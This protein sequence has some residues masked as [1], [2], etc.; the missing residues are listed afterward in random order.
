[1]LEGLTHDQIIKEKR[2]LHFAPEANISNILKMYTESYTTADINDDHDIKLDISNMNIINDDEFDVVIACD[3][4]E[5]VKN[6]ISAMKEIFRI[7]NTNGYAI[8][9]VPQK[10]N[11]KKTYEDPSIISPEGRTHAYGQADHLRMYGDDFKQKLQDVGFSVTV[12][13]EN[14]FKKEESNKFVLF[15]PV[16]SKHPL[17]TNYRKVFFARK[18]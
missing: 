8:L 15:P 2:V 7:L 9:L 12:V 17:A 14:N 16:L 18:I 6:D 3:V 13:D 1:M 10:D 11:L 5:H 4:L